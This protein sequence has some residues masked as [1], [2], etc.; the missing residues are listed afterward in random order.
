MEEDQQSAQATPQNCKQRGEGEVFFL[1]AEDRLH[2]MF[3]SYN[4]QK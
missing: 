4:A 1:S 2:Q 3:L